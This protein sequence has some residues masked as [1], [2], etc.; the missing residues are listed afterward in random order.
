MQHMVSVTNDTA[1]LAT[2][3]EMAAINAF[4]DQLKAGIPQ[5]HGLQWRQ[6]S[7]APEVRERHRSPPTISRSRTLRSPVSS[8]HAPPAIQTVCRPWRTALV[9]A[10]E[11]VNAASART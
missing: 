2:P 8:G 4:N 3:D 7:L 10:T 5:A 6:P 11:L 9:S 1:D